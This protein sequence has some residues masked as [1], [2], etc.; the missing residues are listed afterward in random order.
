MKKFLELIKK[1][2]LIN[3]SKTVVIVTILIAIFIGINILVQKLDIADIDVTENKLYTLSEESIEQIENI[4]KDVLIY[5]FGFQDNEKTL[6]LAK[7]YS[8]ANSKISIEDIN[9]NDRPDLAEKYELEDGNSAIVVKS[10][11]REKILT[12]ED[13]YSYDYTTYEEIDLTEQ[14][15][16]NSILDVT[17]DEK[18]VIYF[19][20]GHGEYLVSSH[21]TILSAYLEN[22]VNE[23]KSLDLLVTNKIPEDISVLAICSPTEDFTD[24][25]TQIIIEYINNG[26]KVIYLNDPTFEGNLPNIQKILDLFGMS[27]DNEGILFEEDTNKMVMQTP[28][29]IIPN[30]SYTDITKEIVSDGGIAMLNASK[31]DFKSDEEIENLGL[32]IDKMITSSKTSF[33]RNNLTINSNSK[34]NEDEEGEFTIG[35][36][37]NKQIDAN[38]TSS[39]IVFANNAFATDYQINIS[40]QT[41]PAIYLYNNKDLILNSISYLTNKED[42]ITIRKDVGIVSYTVTEAQDRLIRAI[43]F[44]VPLIIITIGIIVWQLRRRK[45]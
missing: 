26:G 21:M 16:T 30:I 39:L 17:A 36:V 23:V 34:T 45:K 42:R 31:I 37:I 13:L 15:L 10:N 6:D 27:F 2:W 38:T 7:Q 33:Y 14:K 25:E 44:G 5:F 3:T 9:I 41:I 40:N 19:L 1:K 22:E 28:N 4:D 20:T 8:R 29:L 32:T 12:T 35:A 24:F 11:D 18:P 43:I